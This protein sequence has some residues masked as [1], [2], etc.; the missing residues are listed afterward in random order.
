MA[1]NFRMYYERKGKERIAKLRYESIRDDL[2]GLLNYRAFDRGM[3]KLAAK[4]D[5]EPTYLAIFKN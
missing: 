2:T 4:D 1:E 3:K 5:K